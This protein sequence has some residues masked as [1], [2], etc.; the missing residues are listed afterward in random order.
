MAPDVALE[1]TV[2]RLRECRACLIM[3]KKKTTYNKILFYDSVKRIHNEV[4]D[5]ERKK[6]KNVDVRIASVV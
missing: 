6:R 2:P 1:H 4:T 5:I 3:Q